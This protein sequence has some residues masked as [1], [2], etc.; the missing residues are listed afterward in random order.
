MAFAS[1]ITCGTSL[2]ATEI[3]IKENILSEEPIPAKLSQA[4]DFQT[5]LIRVLLSN[6]GNSKFQTITLSASDE[7]FVT[8]NNNLV[9]T[10]SVPITVSLEGDYFLLKSPGV[11]KKVLINDELVVRSKNGV[12]SVDNITKVGK[13]AQYK[14]E[15]EISSEKN[16][17]Q[18]INILHIEDYLRGVVPNE[19]PVS[20]GLEALKAQ[21]V[22]ARGY[23]YRDSKLKNP[24]YDVCDT[25][26]S[27]VYNGFNSYKELSDEA[28]RDTMGQFALYK[29]DLI[30]SL[31]SSTAGGHT[32]SY[33]NAFSLN[34]TTTK[35][36]AD[37]IPYLTGVADLEQ[38][39]DLTKEEEARKFYLTK[40]KSYDEVSPRYRWDYTWKLEDLENILAQNLMKFSGNHFVKPSLKSKVDF[41]KLVNI[42]VPRRG[43]S[44]KAMY[45]RITTTAGTFL[46]AKEIMI[47]KVF[48]TNGKW[49]PSA[50]VFFDKVFEGEKLVGIKVTGGGYGHGVG[51]SQYGASGMAKK[52]FK[53]DEI[54][55]HYYQG[56][57]IAS[58]PVECDLK[59]MKNCKATFYSD[60]KVGDLILNF[61][62]KPHDLTFKV[63]G[64]SILI[65]AEN[66]EK[67][68]GKVNIK[69]WMKKGENTVELTDYSHGFFDFSPKTMKFY[70]EL[71]NE[72]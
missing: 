44:G 67:K 34:G 27:Q 72:K 28:V 55:K 15:I 17:L 11:L 13:P 63:N 49:L 70:V 31:Y 45:V 25:V 24:K 26:G 35:F 69:K 1:L 42:D 48:T 5:K 23:A 43:V 59:E 7:I 32:E 33:E 51:M 8:S 38:D 58:Y 18:V 53:Y 60:K 57:S 36:P 14:G 19:M 40:P 47:R 37:P 52:G 9:L 65:S 3:P 61:E 39:I 29:G 50:N 54:L 62:H 30:L 20:F 6:K 12:L 56:I 46:V 21:A 71:K 68:I 16:N 22:S 10:S 4:E 64:E 41:G 66:F 2:F